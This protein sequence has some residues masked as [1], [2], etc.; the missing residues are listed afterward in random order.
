MQTP[1]ASERINPQSRHVGRARPGRLPAEAAVLLRY[2]GVV[3]AGLAAAHQAVPVEFPL[4]VAV[5]AVPL[6]GC[7]M[8]LILETHRDAVVV[9]RPEILD[10]AVVELPRPF[11]GEEGDD[12]GA[13]GKEFRAVAP[14]AVLGIGERDA[15]GIARIPGVFRH[16]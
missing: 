7:I 12:G 9:E 13:S 1:P 15:L 16:A 2:L 5:G 11:A 3:D 10:Q 8:P 14:A 6:A 4:L